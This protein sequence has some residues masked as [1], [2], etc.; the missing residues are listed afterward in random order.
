MVTFAVP[1]EKTTSS[2]AFL[3]LPVSDRPGEE[4]PPGCSSELC[5]RVSAQAPL[6]HF[7]LHSH[8][9][10][11]PGRLSAHR[12]PCQP[13]ILSPLQFTTVSTGKSSPL[14][15]ALQRSHLGLDSFCFGSYKKW[16]VFTL[17]PFYHW[18]AQRKLLIHHLTWKS[19]FLLIV[20]SNL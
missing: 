13:L 14:A 3:L 18:V 12:S 4:F 19:Y 7:C 11:R 16:V 15:A 17:A 9:L 10:C 20:V 1:K 8:S 5:W 6:L 2:A